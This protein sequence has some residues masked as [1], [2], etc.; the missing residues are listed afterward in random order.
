V[1]VTSFVLIKL[2]DLSSDGLGIGWSFMKEE[3]SC[4][5]CIFKCKRVWGK[6]PAPVKRPGDRDLG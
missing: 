2:V 3:K 6:P 5:A 4:L 1:I